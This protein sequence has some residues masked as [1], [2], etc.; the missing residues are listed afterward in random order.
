MP[1]PRE[2]FTPVKV[3]PLELPNRIVMSPITR[4]WTS[5]G[6]I[7][8]ER[9]VLYYSQRTAAGLII[10]E[11]THPRPMAR[12]YTYPPGRGTPDG[13]STPAGTD[14]KRQPSENELGIAQFQG[15]HVAS[16][17]RALVLGR[18]AGA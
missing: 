17:A 13:A 8:S 15:R 12:G 18:K 16:V 4:I 1:A 9:L 14:G 3:G 10:T 5:E 11:G 7:S 2:L 6:C